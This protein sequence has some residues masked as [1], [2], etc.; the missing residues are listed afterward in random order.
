MRHRLV[1]VLVWIVVVGGFALAYLASGRERECAAGNDCSNLDLPLEYEPVWLWSAL[2][3]ALLIAGA[4]ALSERI[5]ARPT[6]PRFVITPLGLG[7]GLAGAG[8]AVIGVFLPKAEPAQATLLDLRDNTLIETGSGW[9]LL[10][11][12][13]GL[14]IALF[15]AF[16]GT[17]APWP[18]LAASLAILAF[19][20]I[21]GTSEA[22]LTFCSIDADGSRR[23]CEKGSPGLAIYAAAVGGVLGLVGASRVTRSR[24]R[25]ATTRGAAGDADATKRCPDCAEPVLAAAKVCKHCGF[26]FD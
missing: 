21:A 4:A 11:L 24:P 1:W 18:A 5:R 19:A 7:F 20:V 2:G 8:L 22:E 26:R 12:A 14:A 13:V 10:A 3:A 15:N 9:I 23:N 16:R 17:G 25:G 6:A